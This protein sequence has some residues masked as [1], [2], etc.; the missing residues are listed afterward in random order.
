MIS[1]LLIDDDHASLETAVNFFTKGG[2]YE[3]DTASSADEALERLRDY[4]YDAVLSD[5]LMP[6]M[7][8]LELWKRLRAMN[9]DTPFIIYAD[10]GWEDLVVETLGSDNLRIYLRNGDD[11]SDLSGLRQAVEETIRKRTEKDANELLK[12]NYRQ[13][14]NFRQ[15]GIVS[16]DVDRK[17]EHYNH[18]FADM[19]GCADEKLDGSMLASYFTEQS[20]WS[21]S[22][23]LNS[24]AENM[25]EPLEAKLLRKDGSCLDVTLSASPKFDDMSQYMG[26]LFIV[27]DMTAQRKKIEAAIKEKE[28]AEKEKAEISSD[29]KCL[30][31]IV[32]KSSNAVMVLDAGGA[33]VFINPAAAGLFHLEAEQIKGEKPGFPLI[34]DTAVTAGIQGDQHITIEMRMGAIEWGGQPAYLVNVKD[35]TS[36]DKAETELRKVR[37]ELYGKVEGRTAELMETHRTL[38]SEVIEKKQAL[39]AMNEAND[40]LK[41]YRDLLVPVCVGIVHAN[42]TGMEHLEK[43]I[44][45]FGINKEMKRLLSA[46]LES[47]RESSKLAV[48]AIKLMRSPDISVKAVEI[49]EI[50]QR[51]KAQYPRSDNRVAMIVNPLP[52]CQVMANELAEDAFNGIV[53]NAMARS[54]SGRQLTVSIAASRVK[55]DARDYCRCIVEDDTAGIPDDDKAAAFAM[56]NDITGNGLGLFLVK[57]IVEDL[58]GQVRIE[59][60]I[61]GDH[62]KGC[63]FVVLLPAV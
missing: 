41:E 18:R 42:N 58:N 16:V 56:P 7:S 60:R 34:P 4:S 33:V 19:L 3:V 63:R 40:R 61:Q 21:I 20:A 8:G 27:S 15:E 46:P 48:D 54:G 47:F 52:A 32:Y 38:L 35:V 36:H 6:G 43:L 22:K 26:M 39:T 28:T 10:E 9:D 17:I 55:G 14:L 57:T 53:E 12:H 5:F 49:G 51:V 11:Q 50:I 62:T 25:G 44:E 59:D 2:N 13:F 30:R 31:E 24:H 37:D 23:C 45:A 1:I 29:L